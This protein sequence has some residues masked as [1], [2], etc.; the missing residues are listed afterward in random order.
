MRTCEICGATLDAGEKCDCVE[1]TIT[2]S[3]AWE[4][5]TCTRDSQI[6]YNFDNRKLCLQMTP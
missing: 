6:S 3:E 1:H 4:K 5:N 2:L